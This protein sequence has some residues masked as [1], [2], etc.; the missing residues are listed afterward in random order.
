M[1]ADT[2]VIGPIQGTKGAD[3]V[4]PS[5]DQAPEFARQSKAE[6]AL[7]GYRA[8]SRDFCA[9]MFTETLPHI[10]LQTASG[11]SERRRS[12]SRCQTGQAIPEHT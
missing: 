8:D 11:W 7:R 2:A 10:R 3:I 5:L 4:P 9:C 12:R 6:N 1:S